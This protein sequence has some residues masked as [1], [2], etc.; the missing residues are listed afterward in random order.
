MCIPFDDNFLVRVRTAAISTRTRL[1]RSMSMKKSSSSLQ[2]F[3]S[4]SDCSSA[5]SSSS[6]SEKNKSK[7][8]S[9]GTPE[10]DTPLLPAKSWFGLANSVLVTVSFNAG[11]DKIAEEETL[12]ATLCW[13][14]AEVLVSCWCDL[15]EFD[16]GLR[17][18]LDSKFI[19]PGED[20]I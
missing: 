6:S 7:L 16:P 5:S 19:S 10:L 17:R 3:S 1:L 20:V 8:S 13:F 12:S 18:G 2:S 4:V 9:T 14:L 15:S 11:S